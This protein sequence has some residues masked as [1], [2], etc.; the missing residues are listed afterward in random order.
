MTDKEQI[1]ALYEAMYK[2]MIAKDTIA[3]GNILSE[4]SVLVHM[5]GHRQSRKE[6]LSEIVSGTL[7]Y[8]SVNTDSLEI[9]VNG[10][11]AR[12]RGRSRVN[13]AVYGGGLHTWRLQMDSELRK[14]GGEWKITCSKAST[15]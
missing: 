1:S 7:N 14:L 12:M 4:D 8:Y 13:A 5:T 6:Y 11:T 15:Y 3:L 10:D 2:A 9:T